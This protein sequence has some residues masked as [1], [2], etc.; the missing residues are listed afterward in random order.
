MSNLLPVYDIKN[1]HL[2][3]EG[4]LVSEFEP[5]LKRHQKLLQPH[6]HSFYHI[7][8]FTQASGGHVI[9]FKKFDVLPNQ[10]YFLT[11]GQFHQWDFKGKVEGYVLNFNQDFFQSFLHQADYLES[12]PFFEGDAKNSVINLPVAVSNSL[13]ALFLE[14]LDLNDH[15]ERKDTDHFRVVALKLFFTVGRFV[16]KKSG[17]KSATVHNSLIRDFKRLIEKDFKSTRLPKDYASALNITSNYLNAVC[18]KVLGQSAGELIRNRVILE[19]KRLLVNN[20]LTISQ[21][22]YE[23]N[24]TDNAY[25]S[26]FF[27]KYAGI[28][29]EDFRKSYY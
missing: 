24:F 29:P 4:F 27:R 7:G 11:P 16:A 19:S 22:A 20:T 6:G 8:F 2:S 12:F 21:I 14:M 28:N 13:A 1:L 10:I 18:N 3:K 25:F 23:L 26:K 9:D 5:Y 17:V 15:L